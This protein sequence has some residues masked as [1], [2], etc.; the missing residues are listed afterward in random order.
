MPDTGEN[1]G[2]EPR[3]D[4]EYEGVERRRSRESFRHPGDFTITG[5]NFLFYGVFQV[6]WP[7]LP[8]KIK[9]ETDL[10]SM[11]PVLFSLVKSMV[12]SIARSFSA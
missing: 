7:S 11:L 5:K 8:S 1:R 4:H 10:L 6:I 2:T 3:G 12:P 9:E